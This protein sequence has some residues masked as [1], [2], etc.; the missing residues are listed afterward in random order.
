MIHLTQVDFDAIPL[1]TTSEKGWFGHTP[2]LPTGHA[3][4]KTD[5]MVINPIHGR[6]DEPNMVTLLQSEWRTVL[7]QSRILSV[8]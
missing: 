8:K 7:G 1:F 4:P 5:Y 3:Q 2:Y 6:Y